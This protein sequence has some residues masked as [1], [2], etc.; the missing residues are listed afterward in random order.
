MQRIQIE[1]LPACPSRFLRVPFIHRLFIFH[2]ANLSLSFFK[3]REEAAG[4]VFVQFEFLRLIFSKGL[5]GK[6]Q[7]F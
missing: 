5:S 3:A 7:H 6:M 1:L 2:F 4:G